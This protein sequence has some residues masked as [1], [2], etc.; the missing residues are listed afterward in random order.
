MKLS[1]MQLTLLQQTSIFYAVP[2]STI[3][4]I[5]AS[6]DCELKSYK[7][8][9][10][11]Y[12]KTEFSR[13]LGVV[14]SG[15]LR[16]TKGNAGGHAMIMSTLS[17]TSLF[18]AA[19]LFNDE[20]EYATDISALCD[21]EILFFAQRLVQRMM[22]FEPQIA[23]NYIKYLSERILFLNKKI[24][25]LSSGTAEQRLA[26]FLLDNLPA[27]Q[28]AELPMPLNKLALALNVSRA[29]LY[30][31]FDAL[32]DTGAIVKDGKSVCINDAERL[33]KYMR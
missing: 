18:G 11:I 7:K 33:K 4:K 32:A 26:S 29:S 14:L 2:V 28:S 16:V 20:T 12:S 13:S 23:E 25:F 30:R 5:A 21:T 31:A 9:Q 10:L 19:A 17:S 24:Y 22:R 8:G 6:P 3:K 15:S 1:A 27:G